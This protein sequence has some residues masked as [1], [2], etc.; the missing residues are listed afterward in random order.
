M[1]LSGQL[2][3]PAVSEIKIWSNAPTVPSWSWIGALS[4]V[5]ELNALQQIYDGSLKELNRVI[6]EKGIGI[7]VDNKEQVVN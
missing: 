2:T 6:E 7:L 5:V 4:L 1:H 3:L